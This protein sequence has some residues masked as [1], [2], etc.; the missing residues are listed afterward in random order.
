MPEALFLMKDAESLE[1]FGHEM[2]HLENLEHTWSLRKKVEENV[3]RGLQSELF[4]E[5]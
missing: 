2:S 1:G 3:L 5:N 4:L